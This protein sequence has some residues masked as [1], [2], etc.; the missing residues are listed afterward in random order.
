MVSGGNFMNVLAITNSINTK[1][2]LISCQS[3]EEAINRMKI[4]FTKLCDRSKYDIN[5]TYLD[6]DEGYAQ[7]VN[8]IELVEF[9][10]GYIDNSYV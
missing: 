5:N 2:E 10:I 1:I 7:I 8:G 3:F 4:V 6:E 9:R